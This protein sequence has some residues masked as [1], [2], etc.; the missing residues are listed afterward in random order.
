M[1]V[2]QSAGAPSHAPDWHAIDWRAVDQNVHRLQARI[3]QAVMAGKRGKVKALQ[4]LLTHSFSAKAVAVRRVTENHGKHTAG[5]DG[6]TWHTPQSKAEAVHNLGRRRD[7][8]PQPLRR[9]Y[10]PK[11][12][13]R[14]KMRPLGIPCMFDRA[15]QALYQL[16]LDP[17]AETMLDPN[18]YGFRRERGTADAIGQ[19]FC[20]LAKTCSPEWI[21][22]GDIH[23]CFDEISH[24]WMLKH[25]WM[26]TGMLRKWLVAGY[27]EQGAFHLTD[28]GTP[29]GGIISPVLANLTLNGLERTLREK[30]PSGTRKGKRAKVNLIRYADDF[31]IT[32]SSKELLEQDI[33][34]LVACF[35]RE[36]GLTLSD[37]KTVITHI[38]DG[39]DFLGQAV[40]KHHDKLIITPS[41]KNYAAFMENV[42][43]TVRQA[44]AMSPAQLIG[45]LNPIIR[46]WAN[47]HRHVCSKR[48]F[49][50]ADKDIFHCVWRW[51]KRKHP[52]KSSQWVAQKYF[53]PPKG[54]KWT[55]N[56]M[57]EEQ[58]GTVKNLQLFRASSVRIQRHVKIKADAN[59]YD[60]HWEPYF[61]A[62]AHALARRNPGWRY[63]EYRLWQRQG[64]KCLMCR[65]DLTEERGWDI[66]H[67]V[68]KVYGGTDD[69]NNLVLL[70]PNCHRQLHS[71]AAAAFR[72]DTGSG[73]T[74]SG[75]ARAGCGESRTSG[76]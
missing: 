74:G 39:F 75:E 28:Q 54:R 44:K 24:E 22:E 52:K 5:V 69:V 32:G 10:I 40:R 65:Q 30:Y 18:S 38:A 57:A 42:R 35:L 6:V 67:Q 19:C 47:Y 11:K 68:W 13:N 26:D 46:G 50:R 72:N 9:V 12:S 37:E 53:M 33:K 20:C 76:S 21:L 73:D 36:R 7:Y 64:G 8:H 59:P 58:D 29:Q 34:P 25:V 56:A 2:E 27:I 43:D 55:L 41:K 66:H 3:A 17:V 4:R 15:Q 14:H 51:A 70:H 1:T 16:A 60:P 23:A 49:E 48:T 71:R 63:D 45:Q 62:R 61:E 31:I